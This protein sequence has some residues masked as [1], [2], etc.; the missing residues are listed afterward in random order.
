M[1]NLLLEN[2]QVDINPEDIYEQTPLMYAALCGSEAVVK[3]LLK[4]SKADTGRKDF[5]GRTALL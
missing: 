2:G 5:A 1:I 3:M 4:T